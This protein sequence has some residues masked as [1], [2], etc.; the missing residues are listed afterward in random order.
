MPH[1][2]IDCSEEILN[3]RTADEIMTSVYGVANASGFFAPNDVKVRLRTY[4]HYQL[5]EGKKSFIHIFG[6]IMQ[7]RTTEQ[8]A[9]LSEQIIRK[10][11]MILPDVSFLSINIDDFEAATYCNKSLIHPDNKN[12]DRYFDL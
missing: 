6:Y 1:F 4:Q 7:G 3:Q 5:G 10:L 8:K 12:G 11:A 2:I 9:L